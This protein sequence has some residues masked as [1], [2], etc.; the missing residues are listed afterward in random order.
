M[1]ERTVE[2]VVTSREELADEVIGLVLEDPS[3]A[4]LPDWNPGA[5]IDLLLTDA[6]VR[7]YSLCSSPADRQRWKVAVLLNPHGRGGSKHVHHELH[8]GSTVSVRGP[9]NNFPLRRAARYQFIAGGIGITP[10]MP[11]IEAVDADGADWHL[12]YGGRSRT[13]I[14]FFDELAKYGD[15]VTIWPSDERGLLDLHSVLGNPREDTQVYCCGPEG[16]LSGVEQACAS[17]PKGAL[18]VERFAAKPADGQSSPGAVDDFEVVCKRSGI[19]IDVGADDTILEALREHGISMLASCM[20]GICGTCETA[21]LEG[22][23]DHRD[24]VL[25]DDEKAENDCMMVCVSRSRSPRLVL[26][27]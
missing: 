17:W 5:H 14:A 10:I 18:H 4:Q 16:L 20:E 3:G 2:L 21:V 25:S 11:M 1:Q 8:E 7:Q 15:R 12:L 19:T 22:E 26:D 23:P 13:T 6:L 24:S 27:L 9:R